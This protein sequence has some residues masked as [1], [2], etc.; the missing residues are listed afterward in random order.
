[1]LLSGGARLQLRGGGGYEAEAA[2]RGG[3]FE[4][5]VM[6]LRLRGARESTVA[7]EEAHAVQGPHGSDGCWTFCKYQ[8]YGRGRGSC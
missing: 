5:A 1:M 3:G 2:V 7:H 8:D 4:A 6:R